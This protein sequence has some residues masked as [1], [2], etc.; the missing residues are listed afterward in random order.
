MTRF[1]AYAGFATVLLAAGAAHADAIDGRE[2][3]S[4]MQACEELSALERESCEFRAHKMFSTAAASGNPAVIAAAQESGATGTAEPF[5]A[6][7]DWW[8]RNNY[9]MESSGPSQ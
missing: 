5:A 6:E 8:D 1:L 7:G 4:A 2:L 3:I 9:G